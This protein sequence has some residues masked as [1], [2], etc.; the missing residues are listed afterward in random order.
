M[1][2]SQFAE[3]RLRLPRVCTNLQSRLPPYSF[4]LAEAQQMLLRINSYATNEW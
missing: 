2:K 3:N 4:E 1:R